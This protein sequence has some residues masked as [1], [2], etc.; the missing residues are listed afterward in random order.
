MLMDGFH[1]LA[2]WF[3]FNTYR[4]N[5]NIDNFLSES[6]C[7]DMFDSN[8]Y[9]QTQL[10]SLWLGLNKNSSNAIKNTMLINVSTFIFNNLIINLF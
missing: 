7:M 4:H 2:A 1:R 10:I 6:V 5:Y 9:N 8:C 3:I